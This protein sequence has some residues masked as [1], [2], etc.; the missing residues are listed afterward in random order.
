MCKIAAVVSEINTS[1]KYPTIIAYKE[2]G[3]IIQ[4]P[5]F[6]VEN[7]IE[8]PPELLTPDGYPLVG[9][10]LYLEELPDGR[11]F[12]DGDHYTLRRTP[13]R[14][15]KTSRHISEDCLCENLVPFTPQSL[16]QLDRK[17]VV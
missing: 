11:Y 3:Q 8:R 13:L 17:S 2:N 9:T 6:C 10:K 4:F 15:A 14:T 5:W 7:Y 12:P 1:L 16:S